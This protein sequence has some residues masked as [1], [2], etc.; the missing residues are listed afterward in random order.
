MLIAKHRFL[1]SCGKQ[2]KTMCWGDKKSEKED[3]NTEK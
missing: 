3:F 2:S 1:E